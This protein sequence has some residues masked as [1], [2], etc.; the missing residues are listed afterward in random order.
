VSVTVKVL[1]RTILVLIET[2][3]VRLVE[4]WTR[5][6]RP[7]NHARRHEL[8]SPPGKRSTLLNSYR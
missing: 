7:G 4:A 3:F 5:L 2:Q 6:V 1:A 8:H